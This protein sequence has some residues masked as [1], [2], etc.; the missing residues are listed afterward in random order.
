MGFKTLLFIFF[1][2]KTTL[3][4]QKSKFEVLTF[5]EKKNF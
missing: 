1:L 5:L 3:K 4:I 2:Q